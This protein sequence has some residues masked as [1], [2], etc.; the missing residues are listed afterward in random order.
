MSHDPHPEHEDHA[1]EGH[2]AG[3][4][5]KEQSEVEKLNK[6]LE[7]IAKVAEKGAESGLGVD[8]VA[9]VAYLFRTSFLTAPF[10]LGWKL[11][12]A[13]AQREF[14]AA[15]QT[16]FGEFLMRYM[17][18]LN[19]RAYF[20][21]GLMAAAFAK[22]GIVEFK[23]NNAEEAAMQ[24][25]L[26]EHPSEE[27]KIAYQAKVEETVV[28]G[29]ITP[30]Q[31]AAGALTGKMGTVIGAVQPELKPVVGAAKAATVIEGTKEGYFSHVRERV[32]ALRLEAATAKTAVANEMTTEHD[33]VALADPHAHIAPAANIAHTEAV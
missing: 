26:G 18:F 27:A 17:P 5:G 2:E 33:M 10:R 9:E 12:P 31:G 21:P 6:G 29:I 15:N 28:K 32:H 20:A 24:A 22:M 23:M 7:L 30:Y 1:E 16:G 11:L 13:F 14:A 19:L 25:E 4:D 8:S 3:H